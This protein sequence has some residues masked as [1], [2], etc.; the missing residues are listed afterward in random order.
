M[1]VPMIDDYRQRMLAIADELRAQRVSAYT[2][3]PPI[4]RL[5]WMLGLH[6][7]PPLYQSFATLALGMGA[8]FGIPY[9]LCMW[10]LFWQGEGLTATRVLI[11]SLSAGVFFGLAMASIYKWKAG[12]LQLPQL[13]GRSDAA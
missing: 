11:A 13:D 12:R 1:G 6:I 3:A 8:G 2:F 7:R 4:Y 10:F 5:A 9:G